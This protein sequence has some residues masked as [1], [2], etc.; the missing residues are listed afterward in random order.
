MEN[1]QFDDNNMSKTVLAQ[2][3]M[4]RIRVGNFVWSV[5]GV[6]F[7]ATASSFSTEAKNIEWFS[8]ID[9]EKIEKH[10]CG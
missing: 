2:D 8:F 9:L 1:I 7:Y 3:K 4:G 6:Y 5:S 10:K